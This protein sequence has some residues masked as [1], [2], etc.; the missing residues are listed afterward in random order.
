MAR[1]LIGLEKKDNCPLYLTHEKQVDSSRFR[2]IND[3][4]DDDDYY[5]PYSLFTSGERRQSEK[6][7]RNLKRMTSGYNDWFETRDAP[8]EVNAT[9]K[10]GQEF[11]FEILEAR[12]WPGAEGLGLDS[13]QYRALQAALTQELV[14]IQG[15]PG[16]GKT[17]MALKIAEILIKNKQKMGRKTPILVVCLTNHALDQ[18]LIGMMPFTKYIVRIGGQ[19]KRPELD[20]MNLKKKKLYRSKEQH[21]MIL[22]YRSN[23]RQWHAKLDDVERRLFAVEKGLS[24]QGFVFLSGTDL[25]TLLLNGLLGAFLCM[26]LNHEEG[27]ISFADVRNYIHEWKTALTQHIFTGNNISE[28]TSYQ[29]DVDQK[30]NYLEAELD[31]LESH[32]HSYEFIKQGGSSKRS[33]QK[34]HLFQM[35]TEETLDMYFKILIEQRDFLSKKKLKITDETSKVST[36][37]DEIRWMEQIRVL[38]DQDVIGLT[39]TGAARL[40]KMLSTIGC[41]IG[42]IIIFCFLQIF[43]SAFIIFPSRSNC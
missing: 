1:Y 21:E 37:L 17:F 18:F 26:F 27:Y 36:I 12:T 35:S 4:D 23:L 5:D 19:S 31:F 8:V 25:K 38:E 29:Q 13:S 40:Q 39:T 11:T 3:S 15:P 7:Y 20:E 22:H 6:E 28:A 16:T 34:R 9:G 32:I 10:D 2:P 43:L 33:K 14:V 42:N 41:E 30:A 24:K